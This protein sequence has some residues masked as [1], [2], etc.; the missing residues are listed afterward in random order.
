MRLVHRFLTEGDPRI[1]WG[2]RTLGGAELRLRVRGVVGWLQAEGLEPG[3]RVALHLPHGPAA[4]VLLLACWAAGLTAVPLDRHHPP[5]A[6]RSLVERSGARL[7]V[8]VGRRGRALTQRI[9]VPR[10]VLDDDQAVPAG[11]GAL[12]D[13]ELRAHDAPALI[14]W[15]SGSTGAPKGVTIGREAVDVFVEHWRD[16]L[17]VVADDRIAWTAALSFD[18]SLLDIGVA[19]SAGATLVPVPEARL[20]IPAQLRDWLEAE[21]ITSIYTVPSLLGQ[22]LPAD[23]P[24]PPALRVVLSAGEAL[25]PGLAGRLRAALPDDAVL[26]N[27][28]GPTETNVSTAWEVPSGWSGDAVPIGTPCPYV[29]T[30]IV[31]GELLVRGGTVMDGYWGEPDRARW[32]DGWLHTGDCV[33]EVDGLLHLRGRLDRMVKVRG[34]RLEPA[35]IEAALR[36]VDGVSEAAVTVED[37]VTAWIVGSADP[38]DA[39][40][41]AARSLPSWACPDRIERIEA[42]PRTAR[43]KVDYAALSRAPG[44]PR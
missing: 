41:A 7:L 16:R 28:F 13:G 17:G 4:P 35:A 34:Y 11:G 24:L 12:R 19:L 14:L 2:E 21:R 31:D 8:T 18:L 9:E 40:A 5:A 30:R 26:A 36:A 22:A 43:G 3:D 10:L 27:L 42:L 39:A 29:E 15:T 33:E 32:T 37:G 44:T 1:A 23:R 6:L 20:A 25:P 38:R